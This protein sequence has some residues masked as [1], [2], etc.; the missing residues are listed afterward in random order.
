MAYRLIIF[1]AAF[2]KP[3]EEN[4]CLLHALWPVWQHGP[5]S[6]RGCLCS[7][8]SQKVKGDNGLLA[9]QSSDS[10]HSSSL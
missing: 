3:V 8:G 4:P 5:F 9:E 1:F 7:R 6:P 2:V 10:F